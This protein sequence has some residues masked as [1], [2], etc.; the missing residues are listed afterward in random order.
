MLSPSR[1]LRAGRIDTVDGVPLAVLG[2]FDLVPETPLI[3]RRNGERTNTVQAFVTPFTLPG[4]ALADFE[5]RL[6]QSG[7]RPPPGYRMN[8]GGET[9]KSG[10]AQSNLSSV[11]GTLAM[12]MVGALVLAFNSFGAAAVII[13]VAVLSIGGGLLSLW[14]FGFPM[15]F[16]AV[17]GCMGLVGLAINDSIVVLSALRENPKAMAG[18]LAAARDVVMDGTRHVLSTTV[19]T[20]GGFIP[21]IV[22]GGLFWPPLAVA[23]S[24]GMIGATMLALF[25]VPPVFVLM[26]RFRRRGA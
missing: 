15:G 18:D 11:F 3:T 4:I 20:V 16:I 5:R 14:V 13:V 17:V 24:G 2:R 1:D 23:I 21:L 7:F 6:A 22:W 12:L 25:F 9:E 10:E 19:T 26:G 8:F